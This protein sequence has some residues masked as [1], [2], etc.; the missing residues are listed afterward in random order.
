MNKLLIVLIVTLFLFSC[1]EQVEERISPSTRLNVQKVENLSERGIFDA[2]G[3]TK[4]G[5]KFISARQTV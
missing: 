4:V 3:I 1:G 2:W 5:N